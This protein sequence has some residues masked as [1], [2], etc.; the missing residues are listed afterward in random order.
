MGFAANSRG[1]TQVT[2][3]RPSRRDAFADCSLAPNASTATIRRN[4]ANWQDILNFC[5]GPREAT[6]VTPSNLHIELAVRQ[7]ECYFAGD[8][9]ADLSQ[10]ELD[11][12]SG[13]AFEQQVWKLVREIP[14]GETRTYGEI[15]RAA[16]RANAAR[17]V[18]QCNAKNRWA[19]VVP[20][21]RLVGSNGNLTGYGGGLALKRKLLAL[22]GIDLIARRTVSRSHAHRH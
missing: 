6:L 8:K 10:I 1:I 11:M 5:N 21:H 14:R 18:G 17:A 19:I 7:L 22:E 13:T 15:A 4:P 20:C 12:Q 9:T 3:P 16:G 2:V